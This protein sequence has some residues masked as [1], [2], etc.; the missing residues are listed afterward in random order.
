[1]NLMNTTMIQIIPLVLV[2]VGSAIVGTQQ[3]RATNEGSYKYGYATGFDD[4]DI[5]STAGTDNCDF[6]NNTAAVKDCYKDL[7]Q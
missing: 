4:Y 1:M 7:T 2:L 5:C 3:A 6:P